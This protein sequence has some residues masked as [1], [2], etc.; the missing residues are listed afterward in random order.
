MD[1]VM[2]LNWL[3]AYLSATKSDRKKSPNGAIGFPGGWMTAND[4]F[5]SNQKDAVADMMGMQY[6]DNP[7]SWLAYDCPLG[8]MNKLK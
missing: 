8:Q 1:G 4:V 6:Y 2:R 7:T 5:Y 3:Y